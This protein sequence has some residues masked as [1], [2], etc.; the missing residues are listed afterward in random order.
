[1]I[2]EMI[3]NK[4]FITTNQGATSSL[5]FAVKNGLQQGTIN[6]PVLFNLYINDILNDPQIM[7]DNKSNIIAF[8]DDIIIYTIGKKPTEMQNILQT[9]YN[10]I[11]NNLNKWKLKINPLKCE[12]ILWRKPYDNLSKEARK[13]INEFI[14]TDTNNEG[15][16]QQIPTVKQV[17]YL[18]M[19]LDYLFRLNNHVEIQLNKAIKAF[20]AN[21]RLFYNRKL[22]PKTKVICYMLLI[23]PI[24]TYAAPIW[25][26]LSASTLEKIRISERNFLRHCIN[27][28]RTQTSNFK[29]YTSNKAIYNLAD[30]PRIDLHLIEITRN[31]FT[32]TQI[33]KDKIGIDLK[34]INHQQHINLFKTGYTTPCAFL[35]ADKMDIIQNNNNIPIIYHISRNKA[36]KKLPT[37]PA[38]LR[39]TKKVYSTI[40]SDKDK[41]KKYKNHKK[42]WWLKNNNPT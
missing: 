42:Y 4:K 41:T 20:R 21:N 9:H 34:K 36:D 14:I 2:W 8:A 16:H 13:H 7:E 18:G 33:I 12:T 39:Q 22:T 40:L 23:R 37:T 17:K 35:T 32:K 3:T 10:H 24:I 31:Y 38:Q 19:H 27:S 29:K 30:I 5:T 28:Y 11:K 6:S 25:W 1:M 26:N 15:N